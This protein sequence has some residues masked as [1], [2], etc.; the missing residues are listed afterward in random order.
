MRLLGDPK[1]LSHQ[2]L[3]LDK[4]CDA[5]SIDKTIVEPLEALP[6]TFMIAECFKNDGAPYSDQGESAISVEKMLQFLDAGN[7]FRAQQMATRI[8]AIDPA[9]PEAWNIVGSYAAKQHELVEA[10]TAFRCVVTLLPDSAAGHENL[11]RVLLAGGKPEDALVH[12]EAFELAP[13][14]YRVGELLVELLNRNER[15][16]DAL[17]V[18]Q[19]LLIHSPKSKPVILSMARACRGLN[20][21]DPACQLYLAAVA[22]DLT[23]AEVQA[24][25]AVYFYENG[26]IKDAIAFYADVPVATSLMYT[27]ITD[28]APV[29]TLW[30]AETALEFYEQVLQLKPDMP[31]TLR[32]ISHVYHVLVRPAEAI[33]AISKV[34]SRFPDDFCAKVQ[35][36]YYKKHVCDWSDQMDFSAIEDMSALNGA[37]PFQVLPMVD[38]PVLQLEL[39]KHYQQTRNTFV[40]NR[41]FQQTR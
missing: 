37:S 27:R 29:I 16:S 36:A 34:V 28:W 20:R 8:L 38:D 18:G 23:D 30:G 9:I 5:L 1:A 7:L 15:F 13:D 6:E 33:E 3:L 26:R 12:V 21:V 11:G 22:C 19:N 10:E 41:L 39:A 4:C 31:G 25:L 40:K 2:Q 17:D 14:T 24:E 32:N 35:L